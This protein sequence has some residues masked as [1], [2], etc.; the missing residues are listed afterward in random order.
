MAYHDDPEVLATFEEEVTER[1]AEI[2]S[3]LLAL[4]RDADNAPDE[5]VHSIF[6]SAHSIKAGANLL[7]FK[8]IET[9]SHRAEN[10]LQKMRTGEIY[11][12]ADIITDLLEAFD[13]VRTLVDA[14]YPGGGPAPDVSSRIARLERHLR[15]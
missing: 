1:L 6:R 10:I 13:S 5:L 11:P 9:I 12:N 7:K 4:E 3:G 15:C 2:E 14:M 8:D